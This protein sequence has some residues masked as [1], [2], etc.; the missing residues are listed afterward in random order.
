MHIQQP[1]VVETDGMNSCVPDVGRL[2]SGSS[3]SP[4]IVLLS[5]RRLSSM[6]TQ[7]ASDNTGTRP[8]SVSRNRMSLSLGYLIWGVFGM[9]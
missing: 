3:Y 9:S 1:E 4:F 7:T 8:R 6:H 5:D 2:R